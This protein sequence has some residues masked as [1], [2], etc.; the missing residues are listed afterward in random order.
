MSPGL[1]RAV[2]PAL[3]AEIRS[4]RLAAPSQ[5]YPSAGLGPSSYSKLG[6]SGTHVGLAAPFNSA[7]LG[8][9]AGAAS[10]HIGGASTPTYA[11]A[12]NTNFD[13]PGQ[14]E[15][16]SSFN[17]PPPAFGANTSL[18]SPVGPFLAP[19]L[20]PNIGTS[21]YGSASS[22]LP[23]GVPPPTQQQQP[24]A[25]HQFDVT[26]RNLAATA[27]SVSASSRPT[28]LAPPGLGGRRP[29]D[30]T[31]FEQRWNALVPGY[32]I[33]GHHHPRAMPPEGDDSE[34]RL[35]WEGYEDVVNE[36]NCELFGLN[37]YLFDK[38]GGMLG[39]DAWYGDSDSEY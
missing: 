23:A 12:P 39:F 5:S 19:K 38:Y 14:P 15:R 17:W 8:N 30:A 1:K 27:P 25:R 10:S 37:D 4:A 24:E 13:V 2:D 29:L 36:D 26:A 6:S 20:S 31:T 9:P 21:A 22:A 28:A 18:S 3:V 16:G 11:R 32:D 7:P 33:D 35:P 34:D